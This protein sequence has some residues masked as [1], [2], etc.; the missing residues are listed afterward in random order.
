VSEFP[1]LHLF[2]FSV[3]LIDGP[4]AQ[5]T[6]YQYLSSTDLVT[7]NYPIVSTL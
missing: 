6:L 1:Q 4:C 3:M 2:L 5:W 7:L